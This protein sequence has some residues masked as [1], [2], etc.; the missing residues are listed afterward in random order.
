MYLLTRLVRLTC[1]NIDLFFPEQSALLVCVH[2]L[3]TVES[4]IGCKFCLFMLRD[5][6]GHPEYYLF[7][8]SKT[9]VVGSKHP[10]N[11][12]LNFEYKSTGGL[13][14]LCLSKYRVC[15]FGHLGAV[16]GAAIHYVVT[17]FECTCLPGKLWMSWCQAWPCFVLNGSL[18]RN[19]ERK[20]TRARYGI[21]AFNHIGVIDP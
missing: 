12:L 6:S 19:K 3:R 13:R 20:C 11:I 4:K 10:T 1:F 5:R 14:M 21:S 15:V 16:P 9:L 18:S 8:L 17:A 2:K 7:S